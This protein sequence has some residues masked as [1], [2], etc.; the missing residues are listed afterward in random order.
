MLGEFGGYN[1]ID[2]AAKVSTEVGSVTTAYYYI[3]TD[4]PLA[5]L[6]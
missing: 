3:S 6:I 2:Q 5:L 1:V 4:I